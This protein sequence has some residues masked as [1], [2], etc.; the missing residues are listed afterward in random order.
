MVVWSFSSFSAANLSIIDGADVMAKVPIHQTAEGKKGIVIVFLSAK[1]P[2]SDSH[3][4]EMKSLNKD[5]PDFA[6]VAVN[7]NSDET[8][9]EAQEYFKRSGLEFPVIKDKNL[10]LADR[11]KAFKTPHAFVMNNEGKILYQGG[12]SS[13]RQFAM[14]DKKYLREALTN[15]HDGK[16]VVMEEGRT[17][18]CVISR[19]EKNVW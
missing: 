14:A 11:Y 9:E 8:N 3:I 15:I 7:S 13:S 16:P 12:V 5:F 18:G 2:C 17:L 6:F 1:C 19:G 10:E 4:V